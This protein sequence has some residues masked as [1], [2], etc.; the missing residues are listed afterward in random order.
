M[1]AAMQ[2]PLYVRYKGRVLGP[3]DWPALE[4]QIVRGQL[5]RLHEVSEDGVTWIRASRYPN[6]FEPAQTS[7]PLIVE[8]EPAARP[9]AS[10]ASASAVEGD[11]E[12]PAR[13][14]PAPQSL[15]YY[16][17]EDG[18]HQGPISFEELQAMARRGELEDCAAV[19]SEGLADW[20][21]PDNVPGL[22][23][24][25]STETPRAAAVA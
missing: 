9:V 8:A 20:V 4:Q 25:R 12:R 19:W 6:L 18:P 23:A 15:W 24:A 16:A 7:P 1:T 17:I 13:A 21:S 5:S 14:A 22:M 2:V 10:A 11:D 3:F